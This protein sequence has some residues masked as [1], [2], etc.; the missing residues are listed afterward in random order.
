MSF[1]LLGFDNPLDE[2]PA[3]VI[4][5][6]R[7]NRRLVA[8]YPGGNQRFD[9]I[10]EASLY[11]RFSREQLEKFQDFDPLRHRMFADDETNVFIYTPEEEKEFLRTRLNNPEF[12]RDS[13]YLR[14]EIEKAAR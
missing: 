1:N 13:P 6:G 4:P 3:F 2:Y 12:C 14:R 8:V 9:Y 7:L 5:V 10:P 11:K